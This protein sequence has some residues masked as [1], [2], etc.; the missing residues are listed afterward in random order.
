MKEVHTN[1]LGLDGSK[2]PPIE[3]SSP[4]MHNNI[5]LSDII[6]NQQGIQQTLKTGTF[7]SKE[8]EI[9]PE[10]YSIMKREAAMDKLFPLLLKSSYSKIYIGM[11]TDSIFHIYPGG[12]YTTVYDPTV[13]EWFYTAEKYPGKVIL[14]EPYTSIQNKEHVYT[15]S[16]AIMH[17]G[18]VYAVVSSDVR[19]TELSENVNNYNDEAISFI[20]LISKRG[21][22]ITQ[23][24]S[25]DS[26]GTGLRIYDTELTGL[27][28]SFWKDINNTDYSEHEVREF[29]DINGTDY[30]YVRMIVTPL[31]PLLGGEETNSHYLLACVEKESIYEPI[32]NLEE[33]YN[34]AYEA[35][36]WEVLVGSLVILTTIIV[37]TFLVSRKL[38]KQLFNIEQLFHQIVNMGL[39]A[40]LAKDITTKDIDENK[41][42]IHDLASACTLRLSEIKA[43]EAKFESFEWGDTRP[44]DNIIFDNWRDKFYPKNYYAKHVLPWRPELSRLGKLQIIK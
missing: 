34:K 13:R 4:V 36:F 44:R 12:K 7:Y 15:V 9:S 21:K 5:P 17:E 8:E 25:W 41:E 27:D 20:M 30:Y 14:I 26:L 35:V 6:I 2:E 37:F 42:L 29:K 1:I 43:T 19:M 40:D 16:T 33:E 32:K 11:K 23:P 38:S 39:F 18:S 31:T 28:L 10:G 22:I 24:K 3:A